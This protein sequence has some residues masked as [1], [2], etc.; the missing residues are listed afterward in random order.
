MTDAWNPATYATFATERTQPFIDLLALIRPTPMVRAVDLGCGSG[1][2]TS[3]AVAQFGIAEMQG[4]DNSASMLAEAAQHSAGNVAFVHGDIGE[5]TSDGDHDLVLANASLHWVP[6]HAR[7]LRRWTAALRPGG[8]LAV[9]VPS[10]AYM[11][12]H[13]VADDVAHREPFLSA[14]GDGGVPPDPVAVNVLAPEQYATLLYELGF[15][16]QHVRL[17]VYAHVL[18][19]SRSVVDWVR[20]TTLT[21]FQ[22]CLDDE[23]FAAYLVEYERA[24]IGAIGDRSPYFF[25]F[26]R[27]LMW[28]RLPS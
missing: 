5:W 25:P 19:S 20:G 12:S 9:Q 22:R 4:I 23:T 13:T 8:Q 18:P 26:R 1:E 21:R 7:V 15:E 14:F 16:A 3:L 17:Q 10:N 24:L 6:D 11:P 28:A 27:I 2:L